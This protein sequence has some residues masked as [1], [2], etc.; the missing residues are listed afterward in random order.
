MDNTRVTCWALGYSRKSEVD[1]Y[2]T[3]VSNITKIWRN[4]I[5]CTWKEER[6]RKCHVKYRPNSKCTR[7]PHVQCKGKSKFLSFLCMGLKKISKYLHRKPKDT[8]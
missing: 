6:L 7:L 5:E 2:F 4:D 1:H 8:H 3:S